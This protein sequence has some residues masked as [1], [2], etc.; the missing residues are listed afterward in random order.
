MCKEMSVPVN[1]VVDPKRIIGKNGISRRKRRGT[2]PP[3]KKLLWTVS[4][5]I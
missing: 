3:S 1:R 4:L 2:P 5:S